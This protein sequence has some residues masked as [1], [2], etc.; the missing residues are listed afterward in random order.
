MQSLCVVLHSVKVRWSGLS[1]H[2]S[3]SNWR[4]MVLSPHTD[5]NLLVYLEQ[6]VVF[7]DWGIRPF[8]LVKLFT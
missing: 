6:S 5:D 7:G 1:L 3:R 4:A 8:L 2:C